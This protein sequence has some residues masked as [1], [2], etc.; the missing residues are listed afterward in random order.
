MMLDE[1]HSNRF[2][3]DLDLGRDL[4]PIQPVF[5]VS[6]SEHFYFRNKKWPTRKREG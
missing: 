5:E 1:F 6:E 3:A 4:E 2:F